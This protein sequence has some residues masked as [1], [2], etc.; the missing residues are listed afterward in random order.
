MKG[1]S[2]LVIRDIRR[3]SSCSMLMLMETH[4]SGS[5]ASRIAKNVDLI[6]P[7]LKMPVANREVFDVCGIL[8]SGMY[9]FSYHPHNLFI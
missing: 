1:F 6:N 9:R 2:G 4:T 5:V 3:E 8:M 7:T